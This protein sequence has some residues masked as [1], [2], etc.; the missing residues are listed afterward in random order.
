[1]KHIFDRAIYLSA[2]Q[3]CFDRLDTKGGQ[4][5]AAA[6]TYHADFMGTIIEHMRL[7]KKVFLGASRQ[8]MF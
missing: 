2:V 3:P 7:C 6:Q 5:F 8:I 1:M 4:T